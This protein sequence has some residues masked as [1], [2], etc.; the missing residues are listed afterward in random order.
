MTGLTLVRHLDRRDVDRAADLEAFEIDLE[1]RRDAVVGAIDLD[2]VAH[3]VEHAAALQ[4]GRQRVIDEAHG[5]RDADDAVLA[6]AQEVDVERQ[7][8]DRI[9]LHLARDDAG[10]PC[11]RRRR[12]TPTR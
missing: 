6:D 7:V 4:A 11:R 5:N 12:R 10:F 8:L 2:L 3:D 9:D 1:E